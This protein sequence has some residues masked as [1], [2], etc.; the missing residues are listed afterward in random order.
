MLGFFMG[1]LN[2]YFP[3][4][5]LANNFFFFYPRQKLGSNFFSKI[6]FFALLDDF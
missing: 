4:F 5:F 6:L 3:G 1:N 2:N